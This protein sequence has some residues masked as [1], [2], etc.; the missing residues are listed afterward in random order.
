MTTSTV[1]RITQ[2]GLAEGRQTL[3]G[4]IDRPCWEIAEALGLGYFGDCSLIHGGTFFDRSDWEQ[5]EYASAVRVMSDDGCVFITE[6][7]IHR[8]DVVEALASCGWK[9]ARDAGERWAD[10]DGGAIVCPYD[11][12]IV[13]EGAAVVDCEIS[14]CEGWAGVEPCADFSGSGDYVCQLSEAPDGGEFFQFRRQ[15]V[16]TD[17]L[18]G[19]IVRRFLLGLLPVD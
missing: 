7:T 11:G 6:G 5:Y 3:R 17:C 8:T 10:T 12:T 15:W 14:A 16:S 9:Y 13:A 1:E 2:A 4:L 18:E 19:F